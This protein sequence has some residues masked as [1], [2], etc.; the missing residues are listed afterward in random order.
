MEVSSEEENHPV[1]EKQPKTD[2]LFENY[3][4]FNEIDVLT[5]DDQANENDDHST[6][7]DEVIGDKYD[8][9]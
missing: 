4:Q 9:V 2:E 3:D 1:E 8:Q 5:N 6:E 7:N